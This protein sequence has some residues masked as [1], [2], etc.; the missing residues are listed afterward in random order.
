ML[1]ELGGESVK[2]T[3]MLAAARAFD[4]EPRRQLQIVERRS[5]R[6]R[7]HARRGHALLH[8][9][10]VDELTDEPVGVEAVG[11]RLEVEQHAMAQDGPRDVAHVGG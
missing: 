1:A 7:K 8:S 2:R 6:R 11:F 3:A 5:R 9:H 4:D 10:G